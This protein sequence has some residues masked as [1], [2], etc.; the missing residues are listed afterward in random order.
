MEKTIYKI[1]KY[2]F[3]LSIIFFKNNNFFILLSGNAFGI[4]YKYDIN[5]DILAEIE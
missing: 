3:Y 5:F 4:I 2:L 1:V